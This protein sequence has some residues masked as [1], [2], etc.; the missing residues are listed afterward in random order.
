MGRHL[1]VGANSFARNPR[2]DDRANKFAPTRVPRDIPVAPSDQ[3]RE[4]AA[5]AA[6]IVGANSFAPSAA[7][8]QP[9]FEESGM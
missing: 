9:N 8:I 1:A 6:R 7:R 5:L 2:F 4:T 3:N